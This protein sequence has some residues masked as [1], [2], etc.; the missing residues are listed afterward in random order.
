MLQIAV[1]SD[2]TKAGTFDHRWPPYVSQ[3]FLSG[4]WERGGATWE[5]FWSGRINAN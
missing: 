5:A 2:T 1:T 4:T 3:P